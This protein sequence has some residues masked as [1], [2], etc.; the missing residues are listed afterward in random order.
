MKL[1]G[2]IPSPLRRMLMAVA[3]VAV[4]VSQAGRAA[5]STHYNIYAVEAPAATAAVP[6]DTA[7]QDTAKAAA[8]KP[9]AA[10][11]DTAKAAAH[12]TD[13]AKMAA[14]VD[15]VVKSAP[16]ARAA[17][18]K[19]IPDP[20][21]ALW[22]ALVIP[23]AGQIYNRKYWKL[24]IFYGGFLGCTYALM[25]NQQMYRDYAQAYIDIMD[26]DPNT[27]S[28][29]SMLP[30][31]YDIAGQEDRFKTVFKNKKD[32]Y[33]RWRDYAAFSFVGV[34]ILSVIDAYVDAQLSVFDISKDLSMNVRPTVISVNG[35]KKSSAVG[36]GCGFNF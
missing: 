24:P 9:A 13:S 4:A 32:R 8:A 23:G 20:K 2:H 3:A 15:S 17:K 10:A 14:V 29:K 31:G 28:Y 12:D 34:Y 22:L 11:A 25:W 30:P 33:R 26:N 27:A 36:V 21:R 6:A 35:L 19:F 18:A 5:A 7:K 1:R 16:T